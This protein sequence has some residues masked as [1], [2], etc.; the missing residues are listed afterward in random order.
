MV[1]FRSGK[2]LFKSTARMVE[3]GGMPKPRWLEPFQE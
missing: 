3:F 1:R 2:D